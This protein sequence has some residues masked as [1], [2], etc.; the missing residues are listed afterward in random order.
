MP[1][2]QLSQ[3]NVL[4]QEPKIFRLQLAYRTLVYPSKD[5]LHI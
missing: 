4:G 2:E 5:I 3:P 1:S